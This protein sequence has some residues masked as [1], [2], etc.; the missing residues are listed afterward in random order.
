MS[1][2]CMVGGGQFVDRA[3]VA[4]VP[5]PAATASWKPVLHM[6]VIDAVTEVVNAHRWSITKEQFGLAREGQKLFGIME[7]NKTSCPDWSRCIGLRN[8]WR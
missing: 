6:D 8:S 5:T 4:L 1:N 2:L 7:I 3:A